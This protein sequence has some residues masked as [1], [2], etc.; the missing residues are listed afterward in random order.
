MLCVIYYNKKC[1]LF[2]QK[3]PKKMP[4]ASTICTFSM[5]SHISRIAAIRDLKT[6]LMDPR[7]S[8]VTYLTVQPCERERVY[9]IRVQRRLA[10]MF[11]QEYL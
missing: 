8:I 10:D 2:L 9:E 3:Y 4:H 11:E 1:L 6:V 7:T 5:Y